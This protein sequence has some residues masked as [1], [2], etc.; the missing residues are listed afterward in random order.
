MSLR[1]R[2][3]KDSRQ[4]VL[5]IKEFQRVLHHDSKIHDFM[6]VKNVMRDLLE[7]NFQRAFRKN[8]VK[9]EELNLL[10][11]AYRKSFK[12]ILKMSVFRDVES[13]VVHYLEQEQKNYA[14]F[15]YVTDLNNEVNWLK[16]GIEEMK[17]EIQELNITNQDTEIENELELQR[18]EEELNHEK[19]GFQE[20]AQHW[21]V[22]DLSME[23]FGVILDQAFTA[24]GCTSN[25]I[26]SIL[27]N[28]LGMRPSNICMCLSILERKITELINL[29]AEL[30]VRKSVEIDKGPLPKRLQLWL[31]GVKPKPVGG[32]FK[33]KVVITGRLDTEQDDDETEANKRI[34]TPIYYQELRRSL[35]EQVREKKLSLGPEDNSLE[36]APSVMEF[37][38]F[39]PSSAHVSAGH[40]TEHV[41]SQKT[42]DPA[43]TL[44]P[45]PV[46]QMPPPVQPP[47]VQPPPIQPPPV[48][49]PAVQPPPVESTPEAKATESTADLVSA[50]ATTSSG[51]ALAHDHS[52]SE[53]VHSDPDSPPTPPPTE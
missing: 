19:M 24:A 15:K 21:K 26:T 20:V 31:P 48:H 38:S 42:P 53:V 28:S 52:Q 35:L 50:P 37:T 11:A 29:K 17:S 27:G 4:H 39:S 44:I 18:L 46:D 47:P 32:P 22:A 49:P 36:P 7:N 23:G 40:S 25:K 12:I 41:N 30:E 13:L 1:D 6:K 33:P 51:I 8:T 10:L 9:I 43:P 34:D 3:E 16:D 14:V 2:N 5:E 45:A